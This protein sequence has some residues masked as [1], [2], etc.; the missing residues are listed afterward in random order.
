MLTKEQILAVKDIT[1]ETVP[2]PE[3][4]GEVR[5]KVLSGEERD[6]FEDSILRGQKTDMRNVRAKLCARVIVDGD[7]KRMFSD[8][9]INKLAAKSSVALDRIFSAAQRLNRLRAEDV[10]EMVKNSGSVQDDA[11]ISD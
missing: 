5:I 3:W 8:Q 6:A 2:V 4:G 11:S 10:E 7:G 1:Y 9:E